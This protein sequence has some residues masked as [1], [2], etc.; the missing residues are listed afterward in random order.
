MASTHK[1]KCRQLAQA[2]SML[3]EHLVFKIYTDEEFRKS[4]LGVPPYV[5]ARALIPRKSYIL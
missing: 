3:I 1:D 5:C 2:S 4:E